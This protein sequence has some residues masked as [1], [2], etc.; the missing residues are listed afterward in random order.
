VSYIR[1]N[2]PNATIAIDSTYRRIVDPAWLPLPESIPGEA[3]LWPVTHDT[4]PRIPVLSLMVSGAWTDYK[5]VPTQWRATVTSSGPDLIEFSAPSANKLA[6]L[7]WLSARLGISLS[8]MVG[9]GDMPND[10]ELLSAVGLGVA[11]SNAHPDVKSSAAAS[12][13]S[14][15]EDGVAVFLKDVDDAKLFHVSGGRPPLASIFRMT[16]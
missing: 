4:L 12:T 13:L 2:F 1:S 7:S 10:I 3:A 14:N 9:F 16:S 8:E 5:L 15:D 11:V 6:A